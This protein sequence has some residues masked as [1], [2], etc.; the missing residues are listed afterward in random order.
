VENETSLMDGKLLLVN[1]IPNMFDSPSS[2]VHSTVLN[3]PVGITYSTILCT[4]KLKRMYI[5]SI[6]IYGNILCIF[7]YTVFC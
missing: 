1:F 5:C 4:L 2:S 3:C 6:A 7:A